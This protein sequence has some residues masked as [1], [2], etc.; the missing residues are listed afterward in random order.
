MIDWPDDDLA[1]KLGRSFANIAAAAMGTATGMKFTVTEKE[2]GFEIDTG[3]AKAL[4]REFGDGSSMPESWSVKG[5]VAAERMF[6]EHAQGG[7]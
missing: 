4:A 3:D 2:D 6:N 7:I 5:L 1:M